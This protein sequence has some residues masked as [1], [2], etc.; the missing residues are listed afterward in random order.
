MRGHIDKVDQDRWDNKL[1]GCGVGWGPIR[2]WEDD[3]KA[4]KGIALPNWEKK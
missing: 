2:S 4:G 1:T 3:Y